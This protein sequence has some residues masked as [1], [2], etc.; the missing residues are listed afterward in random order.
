MNKLVCLVKEIQV[1]VNRLEVGMVGPSTCKPSPYPY[2][3]SMPCS[4]DLMSPGDASLSGCP[5]YEVDVTVSQDLEGNYSFVLSS[6]AL[7]EKGSLL[8]DPR[9][10]AEIDAKRF[11]EYKERVDKL[12]LEK[13][14]IQLNDADINAEVALIKAELPKQ[15]E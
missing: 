13:M 8:S 14:R 1:G 15:G 9:Y 12:T 4:F 3:I 10:L 6:S 5:R 2:T 7:I 11:K